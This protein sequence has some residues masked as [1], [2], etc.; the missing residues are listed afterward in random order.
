MSQSIAAGPN[1]GSSTA[2]RLINSSQESGLDSNYTQE[3]S[4]TP[5][6]SS[7]NPAIPYL[8]AMGAFVG[9][10]LLV[11]GVVLFSFHRRNRHKK[12][13]DFQPDSFENEQAQQALDKWIE[14]EEGMKQILR[15]PVG[16]G[17]QLCTEQE[18][19]ERERRYTAMSEGIFS[20]ESLGKDE[21]L[22]AFS[23]HSEDNID[24]DKIYG[25]V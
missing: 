17:W 20:D 6:S 1:S 8:A 24:I 22:P 5:S 11:V 7:S 10:L 2:P 9:L 16:P 18:V 19:R 3:A 14:S 25:R 4:S 12:T 13:P 23:L 15:A 21:G